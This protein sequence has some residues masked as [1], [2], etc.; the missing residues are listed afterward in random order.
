MPFEG[1]KLAQKIPALVRLVSE[2]LKLLNK[3]QLGVL[4]FAFNQDSQFYKN[5]NGVVNTC[6]SFL[7]NLMLGIIGVEFF[8]WFYSIKLVEMTGSAN[9]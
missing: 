8:A 7:F 2:Q 6:T 9:L 5:V 3:K 1:S 4:P